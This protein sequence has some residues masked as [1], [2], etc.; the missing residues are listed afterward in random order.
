MEIW[1][2]VAVVVLILAGVTLVFFPE[3]LRKQIGW[4][5][6][7]GTGFYLLGAGLL[8]LL[9]YGIWLWPIL[10]ERVMNV[11]LYVTLY[12]C[13]GFIVGIGLLIAVFKPKKHEEGA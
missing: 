3:Q 10:R 6:L 13:P 4:M 12:A 8:T 2:I 11:P 9:A 7:L 1:M 5:I